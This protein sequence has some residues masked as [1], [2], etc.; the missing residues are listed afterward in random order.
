MTPN[1]YATTGATN[2]SALS[3]PEFNHNAQADEIACA[4]PRLT[5]DIP[6]KARPV[7]R[8]SK[9]YAAFEA[10]MRASGDLIAPGLALDDERQQ[11]L[12]QSVW[13]HPEL[14]RGKPEAVISA[15]APNGSQ[16]PKQ[17]VNNGRSAKSRPVARLGNQATTMAVADDE[18]EPLLYNTTQTCRLLGVCPR[19]LDRLEKR[20]LIRSV[21]LTRCKLFARKDIEALVEEYRI[22]KA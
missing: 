6:S 7:A 20:G 1:Q 19:T 8:R 9:K 15:S 21:K 17:V 22:W 12:P 18:I 4:E 3:T 13:V 14:H 11:R 16:P 10:A 2:N 5:A